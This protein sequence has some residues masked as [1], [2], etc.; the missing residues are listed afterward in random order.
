M[1]RPTLLDNDRVWPF[2]QD[3][4]RN[5]SSEGLLM[6]P[7][8]QPGSGKRRGADVSLTFPF[9][10]W[11]A[12][13]E[14]G[15]NDHQSAR[16]QNALKVKMVLDWQDQIGRKAGVPCVPLMF[17]FV[18]VGSSWQIY[19]CHFQQS[20]AAKDDRIYVRSPF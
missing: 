19:G 12:K 6:P 5:L 7:F 3:L 9:G 2:G 1:D 18:S 11:E 15:S 13:R 14:G 20:S 17:Y 10:F 4:L 8:I 16:N